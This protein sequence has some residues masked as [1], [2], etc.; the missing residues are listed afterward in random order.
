MSDISHGFTLNLHAVTGVIALVVMFFH[1]VWA[2]VAL[3]RKDEKTLRSFHR[4]SLM[5]W[6]IWLVPYFLG[7]ALNIPG[8]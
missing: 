8:M 5:V 2:T 1:A 7:F 4:Y 6:V 3:H